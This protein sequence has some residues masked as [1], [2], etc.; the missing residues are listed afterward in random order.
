M[1]ETKVVYFS[2]SGTTKKIATAVAASLGKEVVEHDL[3]RHPQVT[4]VVFE[5]GESAVF[6]M[7]VFAGRIPAVCV[8]MLKQ[9]K[10]SNT[11]VIALVVY[12]NRDYDDALLELSDLLTEQGFVVVAAAAFIAQHSIFP[13]VAQGRP[14]ADDQQKITLFGEACSKALACFSGA[15]KVIVKGQSPY[16]D[17][18][19]IPLT[20]S[21]NA[22]CD[23]CG[24]CVAL[25]PTKAISV[26][27]PRKT[28]KN[29]CITCTACIAACPQNA[30]SF[31]GPVYAVAGKSFVKKNA[32]R[33]EPEFFYA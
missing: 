20:P 33:K 15:E 28:N 7:P 31:G 14:D 8:D 10:G 23:E 18:A 24:T 25:C 9:F 19:P 29:L 1:D 6:A 16:R 17:P 30:R 26:D 21:G 3:L 22:H 13:Q 12:G 11:P 4:P 5:A 27:E 32:E 2:A